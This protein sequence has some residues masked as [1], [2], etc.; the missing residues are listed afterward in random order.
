MYHKLILFISCLTA[1]LCQAQIQDCDEESKPALSITPP[2]EFCTQDTI[3]LNA[4]TNSEENNFLWKRSEDGEIIKSGLGNMSSLKIG[5]GGT[6]YV[7]VIA[8]NGCKN[9]GFLEVVDKRPNFFLLQ[10]DTVCGT[11]IYNISPV[12]EAVK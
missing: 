8:P 6:F 4:T 1:S 10:R 3:T 5:E 12:Y 11:M 7:E 2:Q 9:S